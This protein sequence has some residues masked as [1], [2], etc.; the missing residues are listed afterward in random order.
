[1]S[2]WDVELP[3][4]KCAVTPALAPCFMAEGDGVFRSGF[5]CDS[6]FGLF[7]GSSRQSL[8]VFA[9][10]SSSN[11]GQICFFFQLPGIKKWNSFT[12]SVEAEKLWKG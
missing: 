5:H 11:N 9:E 8:T 1:M 2:G 7:R 10:F 4:A 12:H 6:R 3:G